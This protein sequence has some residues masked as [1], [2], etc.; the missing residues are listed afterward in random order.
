[1]A[2]DAKDVHQLPQAKRMQMNLNGAD[3]IPTSTPAAESCV[4]GM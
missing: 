2:Q 4:L 1:M 3:P